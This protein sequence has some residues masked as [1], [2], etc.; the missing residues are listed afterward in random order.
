MKILLRPNLCFLISQKGNLKLIWKDGIITSHRDLDGMRF[1]H[2]ILNSSHS[3]ALARNLADRKTIDDHLIVVGAQGVHGRDYLDEVR[4]IYPSTSSETENITIS[5][6]SDIVAIHGIFANKTLELMAKLFELGIPVVWCIWGGDVRILENPNNVTFLNRLKAVVCSPGETHPYPTL[7]VPELTDVMFYQND[8]QKLSDSVEKRD[9]IILGN[10]G[11]ASN[12]HPYLIEIAK[13]F[14]GYELYFPFAYNA[15]PDYLEKLRDT[16]KSEAISNFTFQTQ[17]LSYDD[18]AREISVAK[19]MLVAHDRQQS[20]GSLQLAY[21]CDCKI[22]MKRVITGNDRKSR[23]NPGFLAMLSYGCPDIN[24][25][26]MLETIDQRGG[27]SLIETLLSSK[28]RF[29]DISARSIREHNNDF[30]KLK[31]ICLG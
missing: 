14:A 16:L 8:I 17:M 1:V 29:P 15:G 10:S 18:Y 31:R 25:I 26:T 27:A 28:N 12:N 30:E 21:R 2:F 5:K 11:D 4:N 22:F 23:I 3:T 9:R 7:V 24:D 13:Q 19:A 6:T 20:L